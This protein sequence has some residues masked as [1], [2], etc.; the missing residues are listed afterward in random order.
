MVHD[1]LVVAAHTFK[2]LNEKR[3]LERP[4]TIYSLYQTD[5]GITVLRAL[6]AGPGHGG[7][8]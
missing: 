1:R 5:H 3:F 8:P 4:G 2:G 7:Q 6:R